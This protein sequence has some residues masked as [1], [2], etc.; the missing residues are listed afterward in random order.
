MTYPVLYGTFPLRSNRIR[1]S[2][3]DYP[4]AFLEKHLYRPAAGFKADH[5]RQ[6]ST[7]D[8]DRFAGFRVNC[9][10][11]PRTAAHSI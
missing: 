1:P 2:P 3:S 5:S 11:S 7:D 4:K 9:P 6:R 10:G 8:N